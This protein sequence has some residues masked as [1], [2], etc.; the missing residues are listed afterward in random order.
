MYMIIF[1]NFLSAFGFNLK[2]LS[3]STFLFDSIPHSRKRNDLFSE[4]DGKGS[5][6]YYYIDAISSIATGFLFA[7]NGYVPMFICFIFCIFSTF[8]AY[9]F[10]DIPGK[11]TPQKQSTNLKT[12]LSE[13]KYTFKFIF[14]SKRLKCLI[15]FNAVLASISS[16]IGSTLMSSVLTDICLPIQYFGIITFFKQLMSAISSQNSQWFHKKFKNKALKLFG[17][18]TSISMI[19]IG[20]PSILKF[21]FGISLEIILILFAFMAILKGPFYTLIRR[22]LN[23]FATSELRTKI[24]LASDLVYSVVKSAISFFASFL[25]GITTTS[26]VFVILGCILTIFFV[27]LLDYMKDKVGLKPEEYDK[28][29]IEFTLAK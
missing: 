27:L 11:T 24:S 9:K 20:V 17:L 19:F 8:L 21:N 5:A 10:K 14:S 18:G 13:L 7:I 12:N 29:E 23:S 22:Y 4:V 26:Y 16:I 15:L 2:A 1:S 3:E 6:L 25:L 28:K